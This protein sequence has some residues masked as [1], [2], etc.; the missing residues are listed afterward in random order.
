MLILCT[1]HSVAWRNNQTL[2]LIIIFF[3]HCCVSCIWNIALC[4]SL[5][6]FF[7]CFFASTLDMVLVHLLQWK[8]SWS[9]G[10]YSWA[11]SLPWVFFTHSSLSLTLLFLVV[12]HCTTNCRYQTW[13]RKYLHSKE[14]EHCGLLTWRLQ[15]LFTSCLC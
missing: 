11:F 1:S 2:K 14:V 7:F 3:F 6:N 10:Q 13:L 8:D 15:I 5:S 4:S 12:L 9:K